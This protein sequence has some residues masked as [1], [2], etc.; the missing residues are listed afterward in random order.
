MNIIWNGDDWTYDKSV[1]WLADV[2]PLAFES[3]MSATFYCIHFASSL[4]RLLKILILDWTG[5]LTVPPTCPLPP[6]TSPIQPMHF[7]NRPTK[8]LQHSIGISI[9]IQMTYQFLHLRLPIVLVFDHTQSPTLHP[10]HWTV[11][12]SGHWTLS[13]AVDFVDCWPWTTPPMLL[14]RTIKYRRD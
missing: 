5:Q 6:K 4:Y 12:P 13:W 8:P 10:N 11:W 14:P 9:H 7:L 2:F 1:P 3:L